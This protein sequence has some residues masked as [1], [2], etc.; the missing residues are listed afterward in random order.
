MTRQALGGFILINVAV[1]LAVVLV[2]ILVWSWSTSEEENP[3]GAPRQRVVVHS[4]TPR[5]GELPVAALEGTLF[6]Q[7]ATIQALNNQLAGGGP[8][9]QPDGG[10][11]NSTAATPPAGNIVAG[12][13]TL[14]L[15]VIAQ[16]TIPGLSIGGAGETGNP[17]GENATLSAD[18][19]QRYTV[20]QGD[21]CIA[22]ADRFDITL[23][24]LRDLNALDATCAL[25]VDQVLRIPGE[26]CKPP[27]TPTDTPT[28]TNTPFVIGTFS[29]TNTPVPTAVDA[30]V[31][32]VQVLNFG[33]VTTE[34][35]DVQNTGADVVNMDGWTLTDSAGN[36]FP[37][38]DLLLQSGQIIR[39]F[40]RSG[41][42]TPAALYWNRTTPVWSNGETATLVDSSGQLQSTFTV[43]GEPID[44]SGN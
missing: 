2:V 13:P 20:V 1:S 41:Q 7:D 38:P 21:T 22:I 6:A 32:I 40:S 18:G 42:D 35:V 23:D 26:G 37:F 10:G 33:D 43:G 5:P 12:V 4:P 16:V 34:Q 15:T 36:I 24:A 27:P 8:I 28:V 30:D 19:C 31:Q 39:I 17:A 9:L 29:I 25:N 44:F 11:E 14:D 3:P